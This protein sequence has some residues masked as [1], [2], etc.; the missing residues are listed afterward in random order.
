VDYALLEENL[1][2]L[3]RSL[4]LRSNKQEQ[5]D[6]FTFG[7]LAHGVV[8]SNSVE[9]QKDIEVCLRFKFSQQI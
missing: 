8:I 7:E 5:F 1:Q 2:I 6:H 4:N 9:C 3:T